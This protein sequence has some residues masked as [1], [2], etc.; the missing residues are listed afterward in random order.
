MRLGWRRIGVIAIV[1]VVALAALNVAGMVRYPGGPLRDRSD[2]GPLWLDLRPS[3]QGSIIDGFGPDAEW[4]RVGGSI[5]LSDLTLRNPWEWVATV[6]AVTPIDPSPGLIVDGFY[7]SRPGRS[8]AASDDLDVAA[9]DVSG[10]AFNA[11]FS[12]L[13]AVVPPA[14][15]TPDG[16][17]RT[18]LVLHTDRPGPMTF[19][20][21]AV[22]YRVGPATFH[23]VE[24][25]ALDGCVGPLPAG[26]TCPSE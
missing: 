17:A 6:E 4:A 14:G 5:Y 3:D 7:L 20:A 10:I 22:D 15:P 18:L 1:V 24:H 19:S 25:F 9:Q 11:D 23:A 26:V 21:L 12:A 8:S 16:D 2:D 13:P